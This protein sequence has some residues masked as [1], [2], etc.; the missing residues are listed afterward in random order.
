MEEDTMKMRSTS[1]I[2]LL[3]VFV[4]VATSSVPA[5][6]T[7]SG[8]L[9]GNVAD[10]QGAAVAN[11]QVT[12]KNDQTGTEFKAATNDEGGWSIPS[13][14]NGTYTIT[15]TAAGFKSTIVQNVKVDAGTAASVNATLE[16]GGASEQVVVTSGGSVIQTESA[17]VASTIV[18]R[19]IGELPWATRD[20]MQLVLTLPG[21]QTP[22]APRTSSV[23][24][25][26][27]STLDI[28]LDGA[29]IQDNF[30]KSS[31]GFFTSIQAKSDAVE[32][33]T[34]STATPG[35]ESAGG[36]A[37]QIKFVTKQ[38]TNEF[39]GGLFWQH[40]N[41]ALNSNYYFNNIDGLPRDFMI[42]NQ[43]G[44]NIGGPFIIPKL[45]NG[46]D[47]AFFF[48][49]YEEFRLPQVYDSP[50]RTVLTN[51]AMRGIFTYKDSAGAIR[52]V[53]LFAVAGRG[54]G[55]NTYPSTID[56]T[57]ATALGLIDDASRSGVLKSRIETNNDYNRLNLNFQD[58]GRNLR[59]FP[60]TRLDFNVT[61]DHHV[62]FVHNYQHYFSDPDGVNAQLNVYP[63]AGIVVGT[64]GTTGSIYRNAFSFVMAERWTIS[65]SL[66]N[67]IR[68]TS[69]GNGT[70]VFT[71]EFAPGLFHL[72]DG[73]AVSNPFSSPFFSRSTQSRRNTPVKGLTDNL[74]WQKGTHAFNFGLAYTR[75]NS[76]TQA[77]GRHTVPGVTLGI[78]A[79]D[80]INTGSTNIFNTTNFPGSTAAQRTDA[81]NLYALLTARVSA[82]SRTAAFDEERRDFQFI[83]TTE[84]NHQ[85][86]WG[87]YGQDSWKVKPNL[88]LNYGLRWEFQP[89]PVNDN[90]VYTR[91]GLEGIFGVSGVGNLFKPGVFEGRAPE[92]RLLGKDKAFKN[93]Y[94]DL[95]PTFGFA[96]S[97]ERS[98]G[99]LGR[100]FGN[101]NRSVIRG[102]YSIAYAR[103]GF[104][105]FNA[106]YGANE[107]PSIT[108]GLNPTS[109]PEEFGPP[110]SVLFR[111]RNL[112]FRALPD[113]PT[114]PFAAR[115]GV[116]INDFNPDIKAGYVQ[117]W[118][119]GFQREITKDMAF[120]IRYVGNHGTH[121]WRQYELSEVNIFENGFLDEFKIAMENLRLARLANSNSNNFGNQN[122]PG[123]RPIPIIQT[124]LATTNDITFATTIS[125]GEAGRLAN[126]IASNVARMNRL[127]NAGLVPFVEVPDPA[128]PSRTIKLS[129]FFVVNPTS[130]GNAFIMDNGAGST[131]NALALELRRRLSNGLLVQGSYVWSKSLTNFYCN[132]SSVFCQPTTLRDFEYDK[133][134][135]P[136]DMRH[137][138]KFDWIHELPIGPGRRFLDG[139]NQVVGKL[140]EGWQ[141]GGVARIQ[142][143]TPSLLTS[144]RFT[145]NFNAN[146]GDSGVVLHNIDAKQLQ[147]LV[148]IRKTTVCDS[149]GNCQGVVF[150]LPQSIIDNSLAAFELGGKTLADLDPTKPYIGPPTEPGKLGSKIYLFG[151]WTSR[152]DL[153]L[154]K[155]TRVSEGTNFE[156]RVQFLNAFNQAGIM[157]RDADTNNSIITVNS[158]AFGQTRAAYRDFTVSGTNDPGGR[159]IEFQLRFNF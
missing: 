125:R 79:G 72:F 143:G 118:T 86:E 63:G 26:P 109:N 153:N 107:V 116:A 92:F 43:A 33:V 77:V 2:G 35:A 76:F 21:V 36:G 19:Q 39:H 119:F 13:I 134:P 99:I 56:P 98:K 20:A 65:N 44:G 16:V 127:I 126:N 133:G 3:L 155:R 82:T 55:G 5:Q 51:D 29:N 40:R 38:G 121:L 34:I 120:E 45:F 150:W 106:M 80:P 122:L 31:D 149:L 70:S 68:L 9:T 130:P 50:T 114:F 24:G 28:S 10:S 148:K 46:R 139:G 15:I 103:E 146:G 88:T 104:N 112:P 48:V 140:L 144:G 131:Y 115:Q 142:S 154:M 69:A 128:D 66:V 53:D 42:L 91:N 47:K 37:V 4:L 151:P 59:R 97:P 141:W 27:K 32:E 145:A 93:R 67:E 137:Q 111:D 135:A 14:E 22:G 101:Q 41:T 81:A 90:G 110:G 157:I 138:L 132:S 8:R 71:R 102:G 17:N 89:S 57:V 1:R 54:A 73:F 30:L 18:G 123:Q 105:A 11:A 95:A 74:N 83:P 84:R 136:R 87:I 85:N 113:T 96:W 117:S 158:S 61:K 25:L 23:N 94:T 156:F 49:N 75:I 147:S 108:L 129:N 6:V 152:F 62:E 124:A 58:P 60:T 78:A 159:L 7:T 100:L 12:V 64:P 52:Q